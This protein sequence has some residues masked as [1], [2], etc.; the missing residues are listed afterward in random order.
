MVVIG[1]WN[2]ENLYRPGGQF[3]PKNQAAYEAKLTV[4]AAMITAANPD[5]LAVQ[6]IGEPAALDDLVT[7]LPGTWHTTLS[8]HPDARGI[9]V[10]FLTRTAPATTEQVVD[11]PPP[12]RPVQVGDAPTDEAVG[13]AAAPCTSTLRTW[14]VR[15]G[16]W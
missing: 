7:Q 6:E 12:L 4:L 11:F 9:R 1:T 16:T 8:T 13:M 14:A 2:L 5:V 3:G 15:P 10:G